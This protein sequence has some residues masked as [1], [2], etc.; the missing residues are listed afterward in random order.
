MTLYS[1]AKLDPLLELTL[2]IKALDHMPSEKLVEALALI[3]AGR[4]A[5]YKAEWLLRPNV[6]LACAWGQAGFV[7]QATL[8]RSLD[9]LSA[10]SVRQVRGA[11]TS[12][13]R[14]WAQACQHDFGG[15]PLWLDGDLTGLPASKRAVGSEKRYFWGNK[16]HR[17]AGGAV[18]L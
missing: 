18:H 6:G 9:A 3:L 16:P 8:A 15:G 12:I 7:Q 5:T 17:A 11:F 1:Y 14:T 4:R 10:T 13:T 2:P